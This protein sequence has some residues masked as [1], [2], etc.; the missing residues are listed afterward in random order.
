MTEI[1]PEETRMKKKEKKRGKK[2]STGGL[3]IPLPAFF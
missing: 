2:G 1:I 3:S